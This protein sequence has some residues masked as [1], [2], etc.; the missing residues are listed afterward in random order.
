MN[1]KELKNILNDNNVPRDY[2]FIC[3]R[4]NNDQRCCLEEKEGKW[5]VYY[6]EKGIGFDEAIFTTEHD[7][8]N[9]MLRR[10]I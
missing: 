9:E 1:I 7:A 10:L 8:C 4:G 5:Y 2:Y 6:I 3:E